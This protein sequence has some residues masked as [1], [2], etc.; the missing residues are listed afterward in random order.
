MIGR[1]QAADAVVRPI[2][3]R[4]VNAVVQLCIEHAAFEQAAFCADGKIEELSRA[5]FA[6]EPQLWGVVVEVD[7]AVVGY[8]TCTRGFSTWQ[9]SNYLH[10]ASTG[11]VL[12]AAS[13]L[14][15]H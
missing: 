2:Q 15:G 8:A 1:T 3:P 14:G 6:T 13:A 4:D 11:H 5:L 9:A 12:T 7:D 10:M